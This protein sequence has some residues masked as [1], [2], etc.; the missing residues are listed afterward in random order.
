MPSK[1]SRKIACTNSSSLALGYF[2]I[3]CAKD[4]LQALVQGGQYPTMARC[5]VHVGEHDWQSNPVHVAAF[6]K[7][8]HDDVDQVA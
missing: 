3:D 5:E 8:L 7:R 6:G 1:G 2:C 4:R